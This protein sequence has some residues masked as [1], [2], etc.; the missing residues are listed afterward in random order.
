MAS[1]IPTATHKMVTQI[2]YEPLPCYLVNT[3]IDTYTAGEVF[4]YKYLMKSKENEKR[5][6]WKNILSE[7]F[8]RLVDGFPGKVK[9]GINTSL[10]F[11]TQQYTSV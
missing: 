4:K 2:E 3:V 1:T 9:K 11:P 8:G 6:C 5:D 10:V 7:E